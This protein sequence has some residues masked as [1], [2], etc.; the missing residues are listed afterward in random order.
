M[1]V[2]LLAKNLFKKVRSWFMTQEEAEQEERTN[3]YK[4]WKE[5]DKQKDKRD[6]KL[7][8]DIDEFSKLVDDLDIKSSKKSSSE[9]KLE[10]LNNKKKELEKEVKKEKEEKAEELKHINTLRNQVID[11]KEG[12]FQLKERINNISQ[13][14]AQLDRELQLAQKEQLKIENDERK[15]KKEIKRSTG[16]FSRLFT[17]AKKVEL[18]YNSKIIDEDFNQKY[19]DIIDEIEQNKN[20]NKKDTI[21]DEIVS[22]AKD[23]VKDQFKEWMIDN[24][25]NNIVNSDEFAIDIINDKIANYNTLEEYKNCIISATKTDELLN[26]LTSN[27]DLKTDA[28]ESLFNSISSTMDVIETGQNKELGDYLYNKFENTL[29]E[30]FAG[31]ENVESD[32]FDSKMFIDSVDNISTVESGI[33]NNIFAQEKVFNELSNKYNL[34][35]ISID[36]LSDNNPKF[37]L[38][39]NIYDIASDQLSSNQNESSQLKDKFINLAVDVINNNDKLN[40]DSTLFKFKSLANA[41]VDD[42]QKALYQF[43][44]LTKAKGLNMGFQIKTNQPQ[45]VTRSSS[46]PTIYH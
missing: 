44:K 30:T 19:K 31:I 43:E 35:E 21:I 42:P 36:F 14:K 33:A 22:Y 8:K 27:I 45:T 39:R 38:L 10:T 20:N 1:A 29:K 23:E 26:T 4:N 34:K 12:S 32:F 40:K 46:A 2:A 24:L 7:T 6:K 17:K 28:K 41:I 25:S 15:L 13:I 37:E 3:R 5:E 11:L 9:K 16:T 18:E